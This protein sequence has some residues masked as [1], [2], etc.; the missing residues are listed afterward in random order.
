MDNDHVILQPC[1]SRL[2]YLAIPL[3]YHCSSPDDLHFAISDN[4]LPAIAK[5]LPPYILQHFKLARPGSG[6][7]HFTTAVFAKP[8]LLHIIQHFAILQNL[9]DLVNP[10][11]GTATHFA[12]LSE[13]RAAL[14]DL[15]DPASLYRRRPSCSN[16]HILHLQ[17]PASSPTAIGT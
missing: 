5:L 9:Q 12:R 1:S 6:S 15:Q 11:L 7:Q 10:S 14:K 4:P 2:Q 13:C 3:Q 16:T 17:D 8:S